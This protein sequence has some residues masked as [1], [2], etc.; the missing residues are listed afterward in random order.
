MRDRHEVHAIKGDGEFHANDAVDEE[1]VKGV[2]E[3]IDALA[4]QDGHGYSVGEEALEF[5]EAVGVDEVDLIENKKSA[6]V[7]GTEFA[8]NFGGG[9]IEFLRVG[10]TGVDH[11]DEEVSED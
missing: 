8:E 11:V 2:V 6:F 4:G 3:G 1:G 7:G 9:L 5:A 10:R